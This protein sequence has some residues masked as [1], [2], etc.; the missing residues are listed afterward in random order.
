M[1]V[2]P[3]RRETLAEYNERLERETRM[4]V[5]RWKAIKSL[6]Y[7]ILMAATFVAMTAFDGTWMQAAV[8][9][10]SVIVVFIGEVH[11]IEVANLITV[12]FSNQDDP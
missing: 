2:L 1:S 9:G 5:E 11:E 8:F 6:V 4:P 12:T 7:A 3:H 10:V